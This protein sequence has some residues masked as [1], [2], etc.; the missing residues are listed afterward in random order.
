MGGTM[1]LGLYP[2]DL[3]TGLD[4]GGGV[5]RRPGRGAA[6]P[7]LRGQQQVPRRPRGG[8]AG[9][10]RAEPRPRARR[11]R[12]AAPRRPPVLRGHPGAPG[13]ALASHP[14]AP[15][16]Q[17]ADRRRDRCGSASSGSRSTRAV[18]GGAC[19]S[20]CPSPP[21]DRRVTRD[22]EVVIEPGR[23]LHDVSET[24]PVVQSDTRFE[25]QIVTAYTDTI[26]G[27]DGEEF[28]REVVEH[29]GAVAVA[30]VDERRSRVR[31][32][33][34]PPP[35]GRAPRRAAGRTARRAGRGPRGRAGVSWR[36]RQGCG[37]TVVGAGR[38]V[39]VPG[40]PGRA[41]PDLPRARDCSEV[42]A[43]G[44]LR[45]GSRGGRHGP[46]LDSAGRPGRPGSSPVRSRTGWRCRDRS[47]CGPVAT[48]TRL[49][50]TS[51]LRISL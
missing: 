7:P 35:G 41:G 45:G 1:R 40:H 48:K 51:R 38:R 19:P 29:H 6:P 50:S 39:H 18:C 43:A 15:A 27:P 16:V 34:V 9:V 32:H 4:R 42:P 24:W 36:R 49:D 33:P 28:V 46:A 30:A 31:A 3:T 26:R 44:R 5:R 13:A 47:R 14:A 8:R 37:P 25:G 20:P 23:R 11:V 22:D 2:A 17:R 12:R 21:S 10:L